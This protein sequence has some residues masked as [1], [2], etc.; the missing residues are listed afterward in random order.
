MSLKIKNV[1]IHEINKEENSLPVVSL[2]EHKLNYPNENINSLMDKLD[3]VFKN[4]IPKRAKLKTNSKFRDFIKTSDF[5]GKSKELINNLS[6]QLT[7]LHQAKGGYFLF[8][9]YKAQNN[10]LAVFILR[11]TEGFITKN[12]GNEYDIDTVVHLDTNKLAM[13]MRINLDIFNNNEI[14][15]DKQ[16]Y[17]SL[18]RGNT[19][20]SQY[21][22]NWIEIDDTQSESADAISLIEIANNIDLPEGIDDRDELK[23]KIGEFADNATNNI[24]DLAALS[25]SIFGNKECLA[26]YCNKNNIDID[27]QF[28]ISRT[29]INKFFKVIA[30][31]DGINIS[32]DREKFE[33]SINIQGDNLIIKSPKLIEEIQSRIDG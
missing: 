29:N 16:R 19:D 27:S 22:D 21:F 14:E 8:V 26:D 15:K 4:K 2:S 31:A 30:K 11:N 3:D 13:G 12:E 6:Q 9:E 32:F 33:D 20:V 5:L 7:N 23:R 10:F 17:V 25:S 1:V 24:V 18:I 28:K